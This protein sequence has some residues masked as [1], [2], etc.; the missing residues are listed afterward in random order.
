MI[1]IVTNIPSY[2][3]HVLADQITSKRILLIVDENILQ[4]SP[5]NV[6]HLGDIYYNSMTFNGS[7]P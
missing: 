6:F 7:I 5:D 3:L 4:I 2:Y 1:L